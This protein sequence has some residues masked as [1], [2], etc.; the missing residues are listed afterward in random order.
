M[1]WD[2]IASTVF[3]LQIVLGIREIQYLLGAKYS[4]MYFRLG[5]RLMSIFN[6]Y[7][8]YYF[9]VSID[10]LLNIFV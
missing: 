7:F 4:E 5:Q 2:V 9:L 3:P 1:T 8:A 6:N 10:S